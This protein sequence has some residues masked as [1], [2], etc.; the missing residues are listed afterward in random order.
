MAGPAWRLWWIVVVAG[1]YLHAHGDQGVASRWWDT[2][3]GVRERCQNRKMRLTS[4]VKIG[5]QKGSMRMADEFL[6]AGDFK[7][8]V[9]SSWRAG[10]AQ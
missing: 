8:E 4:R 7:C 3:G 2:R 5:S 10:W 9:E 6:P 1:L